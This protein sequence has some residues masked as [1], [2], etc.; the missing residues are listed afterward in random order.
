MGSSIQASSK[1]STTNITFGEDVEMTSRDLSRA[2]WRKSAHSGGSNCVEVAGNLPAIV[3][4]R[5]SKNP[6]GPALAF[7]R[8]VW[9][10]FTSQVKRGRFDQD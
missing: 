5:D 4:V 7:P 10:A 1:E 6:A 2:V 9:G 3:A 8:A